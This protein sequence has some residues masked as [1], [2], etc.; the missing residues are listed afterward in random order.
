MWWGGLCALIT[1]EATLVGSLINAGLVLG[2][3][4]DELRR[5]A[6]Q[7]GGWATGLYPIPIKKIISET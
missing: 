1:L 3:R 2:E 5:V 4:P 7:V 6:L